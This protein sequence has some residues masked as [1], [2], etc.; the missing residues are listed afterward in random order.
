MDNAFQ[1]YEGGGA[2]VWCCDDNF[3]YTNM[4]IDPQ[5][6]AYKKAIADFTSN[7][8][9]VCEAYLNSKQDPLSMGWDFHPW[10]QWN[11]GEMGDSD[12]PSSS[13]LKSRDLGDPG[14]SNQLANLLFAIL[15]GPIDGDDM[16]KAQRNICNYIST[17]TEN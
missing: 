10:G 7:T 6:V 9:D 11:I 14:T 1:C 17:I 8:T 5:L 13:K 12:G 16:L 3:T 4:T 15:T 2:Q